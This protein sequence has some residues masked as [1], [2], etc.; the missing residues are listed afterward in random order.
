MVPEGRV[1]T[2]TGLFRGDAQFVSRE[3]AKVRVASV[4]RR[5]RNR[6]FGGASKGTGGD[7]GIPHHHFIS[8]GR[9]ARAHEVVKINL[10]QPAYPRHGCQRLSLPGA[11]PTFDGRHKTLQGLAVIALAC[12]SWQTPLFVSGV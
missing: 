12:M 8:A 11:I 4:L 2:G 7:G 9:V 3:A 10:S 5:T 6:V 1:A